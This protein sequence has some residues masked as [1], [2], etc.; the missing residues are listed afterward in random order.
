MFLAGLVVFLLALTAEAEVGDS[1]K[2]SFC[3][4]TEQCLLFDLI[5][6]TEYFEVRHY[7]G[8]KWVTVTETS[9]IMEFAA[10]K[11][12]KQLYKYINGE[13]ENGQKIEMTSPVIVKI[14]DKKFW[15]MGIYTVSFLLP[16]EHQSNP[17]K[18]ANTNVRFYDSEDTYMYVS[19]YGG[20]MSSISDKKEASKLMKALK[21]Y[22]A[23]FKKDCHY[24]AAYNGPMTLWNRHNEVWFVAEGDPVC[25]SSEEME[26]PY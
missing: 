18:P 21:S 8:V 22:Y 11:A 15:E 16:K 5:C 2:V 14:V 26:T 1:S 7:K 20:L 23:S 12:F 25:S 10:M 4:E 19:S 13:N 24:G 6:E 17:P 3:S 9:Y